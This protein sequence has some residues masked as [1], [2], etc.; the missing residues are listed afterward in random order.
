MQ[1]IWYKVYPSVSYLV[2]P[3][4]YIIDKEHMDA[5]RMKPNSQDFYPASQSEFGH[6]LW[7]NAVYLIALLLGKPVFSL[8]FQYLQSFG[9][10]IP[11]VVL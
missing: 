9:T 2:M 7:S 1:D 8:L 4:C 10:V 5:E 6:H 3:E 11:S